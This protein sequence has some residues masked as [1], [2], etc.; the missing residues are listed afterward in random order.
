MPCGGSV[1]ATKDV[2]V[3]ESKYA[4][5]G[6]AAHTLSEWVRVQCVP[7]STFRGQILKVGEFEFKVGKAMIDGVQTFV[8]SCAALPGDAYYE[9]MVHYDEWVPGGFGTADDIRLSDGLCIVTDLKFGTG[10]QVY[11]HDNTQMKLYALGAF[12]TYGWLYEFDKIVLRV[13]Q[14]RLKHFEEYETTLGKLMQWAYDEVRPA[15]R[16]ALQPG[17][18]FKAGNWCKFCKIKDSCVVRSEYKRDF[19]TGSGPGIRSAATEFDNLEPLGT[20]L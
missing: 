4:A 17:A 10:V 6:T 7:A 2:V 15:A 8:D 18:P 1:L 3:P 19:E 16:R 13:C 11:A 20:T 12:A 9:T 5:E 14:P